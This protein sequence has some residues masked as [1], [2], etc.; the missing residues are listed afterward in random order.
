MFISNS[1]SDFG[2]KPSLQSTHIYSYFFFSNQLRS[3]LVSVTNFWQQKCNTVFFAAD[4]F[5]V[6]H[7]TDGFSV[8]KILIA[9]FIIF[10][11][12]SL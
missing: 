1:L 7:S 5:I 9:I 10:L 6:I 11:T 3:I 12:M 8:K 2:M 4:A